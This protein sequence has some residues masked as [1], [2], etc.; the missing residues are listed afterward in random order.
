M[1]E[2]K[3]YNQEIN[4]DEGFI[5]GEGYPSCNGTPCANMAEEDDMEQTETDTV[6]DEK[7]ETEE[8]PQAETAAKEEESNDWRDKYLRLQAEFDNYR[9]RTLREKMDLVQS[10]GADTIKAFLPVVDDIDRAVAAM[11]KSEDVVALRQG[12]DLI[13]AKFNEILKQ[14][15]VVEI[16]ALGLELDTDHH[17]AIARFAAEEDKKDRIIDVVQKGYMLGD[18]VLR[19]SKVVIGE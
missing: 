8:V 14:R 16:E 5:A 2:E 19:F 17:E 10:G 7:S 4:G 6:S 18:K 9:K 15:G 11:A 1:T 3:V 12:V 13:A